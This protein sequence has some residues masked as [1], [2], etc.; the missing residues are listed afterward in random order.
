MFPVQLK[1]KTDG[2]CASGYIQ[3]NFFGAINEEEQKWSRAWVTKTLKS[4]I[5]L[6][7]GVFAKWK[8][9]SKPVIVPQ[10]GPNIQ[11]KTLCIFLWVMALNKLSPAQDPQY[12]ESGLTVLMWP[13]DV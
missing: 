2:L 6:W 13:P 7:A 11:K 12:T 9:S 8:Y 5:Q 3:F 1:A 4:E 10:F